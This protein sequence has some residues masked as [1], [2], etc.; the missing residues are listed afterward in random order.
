MENKLK[1]SLVLRRIQLLLN[2]AKVKLYGEERW[3]S[4]RFLKRMGRHPDLK[5][6]K[7]LN[8]KIAWLKINYLEPFFLKC[9]DKYL[10]RE[11]LKEKL[12][13][14]YAPP[15]IFVTDNPQE[16]NFNNINRFPCIIKVSNGSG[17]NLIIKDKDE[18]SEEFLQEFFK[19][20]ILLSKLHMVVSLEHQYEV[21][22]PFIVVEEL[23]KGD[24]GDI[25]NDYKFL[26]INGNLE[27]IYCSV[28]RLGDNVRHVYDKD[29][30]RLHFAWVS[31]ANERTF[32][33]Y[34]KSK[35][36]PRPR[37]FQQMKEISQ[38][39]AKDFPLVRIDFYEA[40]NRIFVGEITL[41]HG[42]GHDRFYPESYDELYGEKLVLPSANRRH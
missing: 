21:D 33:R 4:K 19:R 39:L 6:P 26:Y 12:G 9:C 37:L 7:T 28:D 42:S 20:Q 40:S 3:E 1:N 30:N 29:W 8:E 24:N 22:K 15:L 27:F 18:Y 2:K 34:D 25:P 5:K 38:K 32:E 36:I 31:G 16:L 10:V 11:Y 23:L 14:D 41:H 35:S 13:K 17:S